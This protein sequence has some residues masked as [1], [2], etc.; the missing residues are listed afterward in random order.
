[1]FS[2]YTPFRDGADPVERRCHQ[3]ALLAIAY[4]QLGPHHPLVAQLRSAS[5]DPE[6]RAQAYEQVERLPSLTRR[7]L[8]S[9]LSAVLWPPRR[10]GEP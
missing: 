3:H 7:H 6:A 1:M 4:I 8:L 2:R 5:T 9:T 10:R